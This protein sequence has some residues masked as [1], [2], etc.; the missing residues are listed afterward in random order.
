LVWIL[1]ARASSDE[2]HLA[3]DPSQQTHCSAAPDYWLSFQSNKEEQHEFDFWFPFN[4]PG[5][6][7]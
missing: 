5:A 2:V 1:F 3:Q 6:N 4:P 7:I